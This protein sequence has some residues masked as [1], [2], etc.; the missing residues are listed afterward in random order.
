MQNFKICDPPNFDPSKSS[1]C[2]AC[3]M[4]EWASRVSIETRD[5]VLRTCSKLYNSSK[6]EC[7]LIKKPCPGNSPSVPFNFYS[8]LFSYARGKISSTLTTACVRIN[9]VVYTL[10]F[11]FVVDNKKRKANTKDKLINGR[12]YYM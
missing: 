12:Y 8:C 3:K 7:I 6:V 5:A 2:I 10:L 11:V 4:L 9:K 1:S